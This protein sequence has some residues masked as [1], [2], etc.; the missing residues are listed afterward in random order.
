MLAEGW[1]VL[2]SDDI[3]WFHSPS[4]IAVTVTQA[5]RRQCLLPVQGDETPN[6]KTLGYA[7][8]CRESGDGFWVQYY[9]VA[10]RRAREIRASILRDH[11]MTETA[12]G[13]VDATRETGTEP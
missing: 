8:L 5:Q 11:V 4:G 1:R 13:G 6:P 3:V 10:V 12:K 2:G 9:G 7:V